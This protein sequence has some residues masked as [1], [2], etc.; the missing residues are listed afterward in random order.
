MP[1]IEVGCAIIEKRGEFLI[2]QRLPGSHQGG[3]WEFPGGKLHAGES[4][5]E[6]LVREVWEELGILIRPRVFLCRKDFSYP[7][8]DV[9]LYFYLCRWIGGSPVRRHCLDFRWVRP[10]DLRKFRFVAADTEL[11]NQ[12]LN[13]RLSDILNS[14]R[15]EPSIPPDKDFLFRKRYIDVSS[16]H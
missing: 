5:P 7:T 14:V 9:S 8:R 12:L 13:L 1:G 10:R 15:T 16:R 6:C 3:Y 4:M 11:L 2:A